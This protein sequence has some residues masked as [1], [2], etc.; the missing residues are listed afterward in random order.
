MA[1]LDDVFVKPIFD[2]WRAVR[3]APESCRVGFVLREQEVRRTVAT[4]K[5]V[6]ERTVFR[7]DNARFK[8]T[9]QWPFGA[10]QSAWIRLAALP[11]PGVAE[12]ERR[13]DVQRRRI[14]S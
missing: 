4:E 5:I 6:A 14:W 7:F 2:V 10:M 8:L 3:V 12:P 13:Q 1:R 11:V 9:E